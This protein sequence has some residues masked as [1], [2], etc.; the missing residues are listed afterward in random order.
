MPYR[1]ADVRRVQ[2]LFD[3]AVPAPYEAEVSLT[4]G[5]MTMV[6]AVADPDN[7]TLNVVNCSFNYADTPVMRGLDQPPAREVM[8][9]CA[10]FAAIC[11]A[12]E[13]PA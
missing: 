11:N 6:I 9:Q 12:Y 10:S 13:P 1:K 4:N 7:D 5:N 8:E 2:A 3:E